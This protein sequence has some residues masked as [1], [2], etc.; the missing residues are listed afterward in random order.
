VTLSRDEVDELA[1][2]AKARKQGE[3]NPAGKGGVGGL[4][5]YCSD[6]AFAFKSLAEQADLQVAASVME[7]EMG[8]ARETHFAATL[9]LACLDAAA[10]PND[11]P[12]D[13]R[14]YGGLV[15]VD[16]TIQQFCSQNAATGIVATDLGPRDQLPDVGV[17][18][19]GASE[20]CVW[21]RR[22]KQPTVG[23]DCLN[24]DKQ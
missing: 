12:H 10:I 3:S 4:A 8:D 24:P 23:R 15:L 16:P 18:F 22:P 21:Y 17:Y 11:T 20:R 7:F 2:Q 6:I 5:G 14:E 1:A 13:R 19:P 9:P